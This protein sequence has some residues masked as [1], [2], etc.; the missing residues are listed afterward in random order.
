MMVSMR[1]Q[2]VNAILRHSEWPLKG[3][4][5]T[6]RPKLHEICSAMSMRESL[7][8]QALTDG[9]TWRWLHAEDELEGSCIF[10]I[11]TWLALPRSLLAREAEDDRRD[12]KSRT[13]PLRA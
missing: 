11:P 10:T 4:G 7:A 1:S 2:S 6:G 12:A 8:G 5:I 3:M 9:E 13:H